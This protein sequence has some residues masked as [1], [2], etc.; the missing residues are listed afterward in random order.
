MYFSEL[1][2]GKTYT[3]KEIVSVTIENLSGVG[4]WDSFEQTI[5][6]GMEISCYKEYF[7]DEPNEWLQIEIGNSYPGFAF[8]ADDRD[9]D[10]FK[11][12]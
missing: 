2:H 10:I 9:G 11:P 12:L 5:L 7:D 6:P 8:F 3:V 1:E 4:G